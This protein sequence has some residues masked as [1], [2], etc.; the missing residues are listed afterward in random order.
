MD[1]AIIESGGKQYKASIGGILDIDRLNLAPGNTHLFEKVL[2]YTA[3]GV[4]KIGRPTLNEVSVQG[5]VL[6]HFKGDKIRVAK[7]KAKARYRKVQGHRQLLTRI[8][9]TEISNNQ[10]NAKSEKKAAA[11]T[12]VKKSKK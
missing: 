4:C 9:I 6:E 12:D 8:Q 10:S 2:L 7:F 5:K 1:Y 11:A 3:G